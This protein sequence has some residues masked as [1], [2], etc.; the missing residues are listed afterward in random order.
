[1]FGVGLLGY[2]SGEMIMSDAAV[3]SRIESV[4]SL[5]HY[6]LPVLL[7]VAVICIGKWMQKRNKNESMRADLVS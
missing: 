2:T 1:M 4:H 3:A 6:V 5:F 7:A